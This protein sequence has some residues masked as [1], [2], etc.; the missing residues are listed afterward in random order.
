MKKIRYG[1]VYLTLAVVGMIGGALW[2][3]FYG[4]TDS[5]PI[6]SKVHWMMLRGGIIGLSLAAIFHPRPKKIVTTET[7]A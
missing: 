7:Q 4:C 2:W 6:N 1:Y 5:C 3:H